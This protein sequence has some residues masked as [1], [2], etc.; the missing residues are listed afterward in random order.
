MNTQSSIGFRQLFDHETW[1]FTYLLWDLETSEGIIID[2]VREHFERDFSLVGELGLRMVYALDTHVHADHITSLGMLREKFGLQTA[3]GESSR[4]PCAD[5][6]LNDG[7]KLHF[8][9]HT[10]YALATPGHTNSCT[11]FKVENMVFTGDTL[12]IRGCGRTDFQHG[13]PVILY[14]SITQKLYTLPDETLVYPGHDYNGKSVSTIIEEKKHNQ[15]IPST[16]TEE[17]FAKLMKSLNLPMPK[18]IKEA[19]P[20]NMG[21]GFSADQ[22]HLTEEVFGVGDLQKII[23][24]LSDEEVV[25]DCRTSLEYEAGHI[26]GAINITMGKELDYIGELGDYRKIYLYCQSGRRSQSVYT[27]LLSKGLNNMVC[28]G[29]SGLDEWIKC[30]YQ[31]ERCSNQL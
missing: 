1:T 8:G 15:R 19:V 3:V 24:S 16:Q 5:I 2:P 4:V 7:D 29:S 22:G 27:S 23:N 28:L 13:D 17:D 31:I 21:C 10:L 30:G 6:M 14:Q 25:I 26:P 12:F 20:A 18:R 9:K 11:S